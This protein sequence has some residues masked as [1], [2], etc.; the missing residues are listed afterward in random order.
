MDATSKPGAGFFLTVAAVVTIS[1]VA[2]LGPS[3]WVSSRTGVGASVVAVVYR[4][5]LLV[6]EALPRKGRGFIRWYSEVGAASWW[7]WTSSREWEC[8]YRISVGPVI[9]VK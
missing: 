6:D 5:L 9:L 2:L 7:Q 1:Y 8:R 3:C 4:P